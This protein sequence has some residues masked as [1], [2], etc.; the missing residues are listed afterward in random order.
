MPPCAQEWFEVQKAFRS[1]VP[2]VSRAEFKRA[3]LL[4]MRA[5][6]LALL[7]LMTLIFV[8]T[9]TIKADWPW[10]PY[11]RA[12]AEAAMV[13]ACADWFAVV[14]LFRHPL[15]LPIPH[16]AIVPNNKDRIGVALGRFITEN[17][18]NPREAHRYFLRIDVAGA[19]A[20]WLNKPGNVDQ[21]AWQV[22]GQL[23]QIVRALPSAELGDAFER[24]ARRGIESIPA[25]PLA[26]KAL[27]VLWAEGAAQATIEQA[28]VLGESS[29]GR[30]KPRL[31]EIVSEHSGRWVP[32]WVDRMI[33]EKVT[34]G[35][36]DTLQELRDPDHPWRLELAQ[37]VESFIADL[38]N[39]PNTYAMGE[40][41][42][43]DM[44]ANPLF[45]EQIRTLWTELQRGVHSGLRERNE[46][47]AAG[48]AI[49]LRAL[50]RWLDEKPEHRRRIN[51]TSRLLALRALLPRRA[52]IGTYVTQVVQNWDA[53]TLVERLELQVGKDLQY[54]RINGT[55]VGGLVGLLIFVVSKWIAA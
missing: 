51:R 42:K 20:R 28:I 17:F 37:A 14:A 6:A 23:A 41:I 12:F 39:D 48:I 27:A 36:L 38:A 25:A 33:V 50:A 46:T 47:I 22:S 15:G 52:E 19:L 13:G 44:L 2:Q 30:Y 43:S 40:R 53:A 9:S 54:I 55:L 4:R 21:L 49:G 3:G 26:A 11:L 16:T 10:L 32:R 1:A 29:L 45:A 31:L 34:T 24:L 7:V 8:A 18:L 35:L 5:I